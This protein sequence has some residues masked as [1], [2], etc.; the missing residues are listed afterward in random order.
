MQNI[1]VSLLKAGHMGQ[2]TPPSLLWQCDREPLLILGA[3]EKYVVYPSEADRKWTAFAS[4]DD[5]KRISGLIIP[6]LRFEVDIRSCFTEDRRSPVLGDLITRNGV[7]ALM[8]SIRSSHSH[9]VGYLSIEHQMSFSEA[10]GI[11]IGFQ[12]WGIYVEDGDQKLNLMSVDNG[13]ASSFYA[14]VT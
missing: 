9:S 7:L 3:S 13:I 5:D 6:N 12:R 1:N 10:R 2:A 8:V 11:E 14:P 4:D